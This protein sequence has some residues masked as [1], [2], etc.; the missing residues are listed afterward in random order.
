MGRKKLNK[1]EK[2]KSSMNIILKNMYNITLEEY[3][4][5]LRH[6]NN[7]CAICDKH[8]T[9]IKKRLSVDHCHETGIVRGLLCNNC[10]A[11]IGLLCEDQDIIINALDYVRMN[12]I[13]KK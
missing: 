10:N 1:E 2:K 8:E 13:R 12:K 4:T 11:A 6:Q 9:L 3:N 5:I 7:K